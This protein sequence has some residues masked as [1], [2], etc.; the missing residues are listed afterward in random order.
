MVR[1][2]KERRNGLPV[3]KAN[4]IVA[5]ANKKDAPPGIPIY[6]VIGETD[7]NAMIDKIAIKF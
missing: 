6:I 3:H 4:E 2:I 7:N 5:R 1:K